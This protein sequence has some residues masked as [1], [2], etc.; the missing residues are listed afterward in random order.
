M[1]KDLADSKKAQ[2]GAIK[3]KSSK[4]T[5]DA[6]EVTLEKVPSSETAKSKEDKA[7]PK[8]KAVKKKAATK[9]ASKKTSQS[10]EPMTVMLITPELTPVAK[11]G[12]VAD[13]IAGLGHELINLGNTVEIVL[14]KYDNIRYDLVEDLEKYYEDLWVPWDGASI[15]C[16]VWIGNVDGITCYFIDAH[17]DENYFNR[18]SIYGH[19]DDIERFAFLNRASLEFILHSGKRPDI[20]H[21]NDWQTALVPILLFECYQY[22]D[23]KDTRVCFTIHNFKHQ[24]QMG[25]DILTKAG[26]DNPHHFFCNDKM[27]DPSRPATLNLLKGG[28]VYA[29]FV[30]TVSPQHAWEAKNEEQGFGMGVT[31]NEHHKKY[32]GILNGIDFEYWNPEKDKH[33]PHPF[34]HRKLAGKYKNKSALRD[35]LLL[36]EC[37]KPIISFVGRLDPQKGIDLIRH[38]IRWSMD[39]HA[40]FVLLGTSPD[41]VINQEFWA[42]KHS[43]NENPN[44][45]IEIG[46][47]EELAHLIYAGSDMMIV[48]SIFEPCG[49]TQLIA[50]R[51]GTVPIVRK[52]G[53]L[54]DSVFDKDFSDKDEKERNGYVFNDPIA[55]GIEWAMDR[56]VSC[57][58]QYPKDFKK[59]IVQGM[60]CD[61]SWK[62]PAQ[63][64]MNIYDYIRIK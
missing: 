54:A 56:A 57:Y 36:D 16:D 44:C 38:A 5:K 14:P 6:K 37:E 34:S 1:S 4:T 53:G 27:L 59:L 17:C 29:N 25:A 52:V 23:I 24:G 31:L 22:S 64:Y 42:L 45:H 51:Y 50:L 15:H 28:I 19:R 33:I 43:L 63:H 20:I 47:D 48:P 3:K 9:R 7:K 30:T 55:S 11:V 46:F 26:V 60:K 41:P 62:E 12:G 21:C 18:G 58:F 61:H 39:N 49:L 2:R 35:R 8:K 13:V 32:G 10:V 40:Q